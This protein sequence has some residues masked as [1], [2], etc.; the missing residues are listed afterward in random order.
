MTAMTC[1][2]PKSVLPRGERYQARL[3][4]AVR[5]APPKRGD[6][7]G[8]GRPAMPHNP[9]GNI[10][11]DREDDMPGEGQSEYMGS[12]LAMISTPREA[13]TRA[14]HLMRPGGPSRYQDKYL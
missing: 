5:G 14:I 13:Q 3:R 6:V 7:A 10:R 9:T 4:V 8:S 11:D 2:S 12:S 1:R